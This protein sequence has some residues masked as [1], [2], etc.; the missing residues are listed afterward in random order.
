MK[1]N[2]LSRWLFL[3]A[4][5]PALVFAGSSVTTPN[6]KL[7]SDG[8]RT[9]LASATSGVG[10][11]MVGYMPAGASAVQSTV[12]SKI[13]EVVSVKD[14]G[15]VGDFNPSTGA[16]TDSRGAIQAAFNYAQSVAGGCKVV[17]PPG[18]Y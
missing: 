10:A 14:F 7:Y 5:V 2:F 9:D 4:V 1:N 3:L 6:P 8:V 11:S 17:F 16:G 15:A 13:G 12:Q 18:R